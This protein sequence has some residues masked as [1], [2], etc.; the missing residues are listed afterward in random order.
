MSSIGTD[1]LDLVDSIDLPI[2][3]VGRGAVVTRFNAAAATILSLTQSDVGRPLRDARGL[4]GAVSDLE[5]L[6]EHVIR[7]GAAL[8][9]DVRAAGGSRFLLRIVPYTR[10]SNGEVAGAV[11]TLTNVTTLRA[12]IEQAI[13]ERENAK[14]IVNTVNH[15]LV[16]L[17]A[18]L[19]VQTA[20]R[21]FYETFQVSRQEPGIPFYTLGKA[22]WHSTEFRTRLEDVVAKEKPVEDIE[23]EVSLPSIGRRTLRLNARRLS[24]ASHLAPMILLGIED[25]TERQRL[26]KALR[27]SEGR[28]RAVLAQALFGVAVTDLKGDFVEVNQ[29]YCQITG[30]TEPELLAA[31]LRSIIHPDDRDGNMT[32]VQQMLA[33][34]IPGFVIEQRYVRKDRS[35]VWVRNAVSLVRDREG[36]PA[37][38]VA[39][40][41]D[42]AERKRAEEASA[43]LAAIVE[44]S[45]DAI[46]GK[47]LGGIITSWNR[48]AER[49]FGYTA[50]E[51]VGQHISLIIPPE[52][53]AEEEGIVARL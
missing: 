18:A 5:D 11:L 19:R 51:A 27:D 35:F 25:I 1:L 2:V 14:A 39:L 38:I 28:T 40:T 29:A 13:H 4:A 48:A 44:S 53:Q 41:Y 32:L 49:I 34:E 33:G 9:R 17:D 23:V 8:Q 20:N 12:S 45:D 31:D 3:V 37:N 15:P 24:Q 21:A 43:R 22:K 26:E 16:V 46:V 52:R 47:T 50:A 42:L 10:R 30:Y 36:R 7:D 6:C